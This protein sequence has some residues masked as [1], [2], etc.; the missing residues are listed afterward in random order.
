MKFIPFMLIVFML[1]T[2]AL[3]GCDK[4]VQENQAEPV[5]EQLTEPVAEQTTKPQAEVVTEAKQTSAPATA[6]IQL[7][8]GDKANVMTV[9]RS[10]T[11]GCCKS[12]VDHVK[13]NGFEVEEVVVQNVD[14]YKDQYK[15]PFD[16]RSCHTASIN[17]YAIEGHVPAAD[18]HKMLKEKPDIAGIAVPQMPVGSP[19]MEYGDRQDPYNVVSFDE[20]GQSTIFNQYNQ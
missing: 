16:L 9:Y 20:Q 17:G 14:Q 5:A 13:Q 15:V 7:N 2:L 10:A 12:W 1:F 11:C 19:G 6:A 18:I 3:S 4:K 8:A